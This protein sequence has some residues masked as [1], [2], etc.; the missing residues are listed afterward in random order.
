MYS[1]QNYD[2]ARRQGGLGWVVEAVL[3]L[4]VELAQMDLLAGE[5]PGEVLHEPRSVHRLDRLVVEIPL[6]VARIARIAHEV[7]VGA[8]ATRLKPVLAQ[9]RAE[10]QR[11]CRLASGGWPRHQHKPHCGNVR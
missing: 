3:R 11:G 4:E 2:A 5:Q 7:V 9:P 8:D 1:L 6:R 10:A